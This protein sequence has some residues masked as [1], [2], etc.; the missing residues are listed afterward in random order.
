MYLACCK[1]TSMSRRKA[2]HTHSGPDQ[3]T[4]LFD[5]RN[6]TLD[7]VAKSAAD[8]KPFLRAWDNVVTKPAFDFV[9]P[10]YY[11]D[12]R[13]TIWVHSPVWANWVRHRQNMIIDRIL[14]NKLPEVHSLT[15]QLI[16]ETRTSSKPKRVGP[17]P[18]TS[19]AIEKSARSIADP[20][21]RESL[22]RL[23]KTLKR[24]DR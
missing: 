15:V 11:K 18:E 20:E 17:S 5:G 24:T 16:P 10:A 7:Q 12:G 19:L 21:L 4:R 22:E 13:L 2:D 14:A 9:H 8:L 3:I 6:R 1:L 23:A